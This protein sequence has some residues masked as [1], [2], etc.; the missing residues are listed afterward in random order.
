MNKVLGL[1][2][3]VVGVVLLVMGFNSADSIGSHFSRF[4][5]GNPTDKSIWL[6]LGGGVSI[7]LGAGGLIASRGHPSRA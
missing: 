7:L 6:I 5:T 1:A 4:F 2:L 3:L